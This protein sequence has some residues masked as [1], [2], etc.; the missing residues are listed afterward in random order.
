VALV[1]RYRQGTRVDIEASPFDDLRTF[2]SRRGDRGFPFAVL[3]ALIHQEIWRQWP[4]AD[5]HSTWFALFREFLRIHEDQARERVLAPQLRVLDALVGAGESAQVWERV[6]D[7]LLRN[8]DELTGWNFSFA[9]AS[10]MRWN[11]TRGDDGRYYYDDDGQA[12]EIIGMR[13]LGETRLEYTIDDCTRK[14]GNVGRICRFVALL[15]AWLDNEHRPEQ[16]PD[17]IRITL[18]ADSFLHWGWYHLDP[19]KTQAVP[20]R[21]PERCSDPETLGIDLA[22][23]YSDLNPRQIQTQAPEQHTA[24]QEFP[25]Q[26]EVALDTDLRIGDADEVLLV[27]RDREIRWLN[28]TRTLCP[29][30]II[31]V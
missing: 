18:P 8:L 27:Y 1:L 5:A 20:W 25:R 11:V 4:E 22:A 16:Y 13:T 28:G 21:P 15:C 19:V 3:E 24:H 7:V 12:G 9:R 2:L 29:V 10:A 26:Y 23:R 14:Y 17:S 31:G 30:A 6:R